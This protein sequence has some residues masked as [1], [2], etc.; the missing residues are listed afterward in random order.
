M[1]SQRDV[2]DEFRKEIVIRKLKKV[3][4]RRYLGEGVIKSLTAFFDVPKGKEDIRMVY[5]GTVNGFNESIEVPKFG[6]PTL[7]NH[8]RSMMPGYHI[9]DA[10]V[11]ECFL[12]FHLNSSLQPYVG[13]D[14]SRFV[15]TPGKTNRWSAGIALVWEKNPHPIRR[16]KQ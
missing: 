13:V 10:D 8:L 16:V 9:V 6:M 12:N 1:V 4:D 15:P 7:K 14:L 11:G 3:M 2:E 5:D